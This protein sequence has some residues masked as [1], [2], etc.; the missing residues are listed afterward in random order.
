MSPQCR[1]DVRLPGLSES[2][3][4]LETLHPRLCPRQVL[5]VRI[6][7]CAGTLLSID[8]PRADKR[9]LVVTETDGCFADG[10]SSATGCWLGRRTL[11][12]VDFGKVAATV[13]DKATWR[14]VRVWPRPQVRQQAE[15]YAPHAADRW[16][17]QLAAYQVMPNHELLCWKWVELEESFA[18][19]IGSRGTWTVCQAC[20]EEILY[21]REV[22]RNA[23]LL[24]RGCAGKQYWRPS[25]RVR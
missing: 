16:H 21:Q 22:R 2:L 17:A 19:G 12:L 8:L 15:R 7:L 3:E 6:G 13:L 11:R 4:R 14:A 9:L 18:A 23:V 25:G 24:C 5:G 1:D 20:G 10:L